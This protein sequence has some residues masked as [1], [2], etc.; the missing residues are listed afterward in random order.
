MNDKNDAHEF[1]DMTSEELRLEQVETDRMKHLVLNEAQFFR[2]KSERITRELRR[3]GRTEEVEVC[4]HALLRYIE[5]VHG[6]DLETLRDDIRRA[7]K[8]SVQQVKVR[9]AAIGYMKGDYVFVVA[10]GRLVVTVYP[11]QEWDKLRD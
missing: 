8:D 10:R 1:A 6:I 9:G 5:R 11:A 7:V 3:R 4:D 2:T